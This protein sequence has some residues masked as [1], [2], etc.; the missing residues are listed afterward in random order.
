[1][2]SIGSMV[3]MVS[4]GSMDS[5]GGM[6]SIGSMVS[7][8]TVWAVYCHTATFQVAEHFKQPRER[9]AI[10]L[11]SLIYEDRYL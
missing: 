4:M 10:D 1:M 3:S 2:V 5:M 8:V 6:G 7:M 11:W 9:R